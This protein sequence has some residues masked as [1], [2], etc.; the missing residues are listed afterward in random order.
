MSSVYSAAVASL[1]TA[2]TRSTDDARD[3]PTYLRDQ[4]SVSGANPDLQSPVIA[5]DANSNEPAPVP[6][7]RHQ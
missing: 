5:A 7:N 6:L 1:L 2:L 3:V 4:L